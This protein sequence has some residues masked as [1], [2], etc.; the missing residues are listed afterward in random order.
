MPEAG[1]PQKSLDGRA[2]SPP[3]AE[4]VLRSLRVAPSQIEEMT[5]SQLL[6]LEGVR[7]AEYQTL[8][9]ICRGILAE[10]ATLFLR[11]SLVSQ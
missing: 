1:K 2:I 4:S 11:P 8:A 9:A 10:T 5:L 7:L 6:P 3:A